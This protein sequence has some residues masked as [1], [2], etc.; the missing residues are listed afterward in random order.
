ML[1]IWGKY[2]L[3]LPEEERG[4]KSASWAGEEK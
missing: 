1:A 3:S 2:I 4:K